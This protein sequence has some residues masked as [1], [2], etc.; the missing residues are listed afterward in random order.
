M[1]VA[2]DHQ[3]HHHG[4]VNRHNVHHRERALGGSTCDPTG[5]VLR[6]TS[7]TPRQR[8][9][10]SFAHWFLSSPVGAFPERIP[11]GPIQGQMVPTRKKHQN[12]ST[13]RKPVN[14]PAEAGDTT[15]AR[16]PWS[17]FPSPATP[18]PGTLIKAP[19]IDNPAFCF[20]KDFATSRQPPPRRHTPSP[21]LTVPSPGHGDGLFRRRP[22]PSEACTSQSVVCAIPHRPSG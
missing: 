21:L 9:H 2:A 11:C 7:P 20:P 6:G 18:P 5:S 16:A 1:L 22:T 19:L 8:Y 14:G 12:V 10:L 17:A 13:K 3:H 4:A 15:Y